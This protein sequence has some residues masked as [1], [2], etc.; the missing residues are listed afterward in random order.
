MEKL[1]KKRW[2]KRIKSNLIEK[3]S[4]GNRTTADHLPI[5][6]PGI[7]AGRSYSGHEEDARL[8]LDIFARTALDTLG[9]NGQ[10]SMPT[11]NAPEIRAFFSAANY[12]ALMEIAQKRTGF[13]IHGETLWEPMN[14]AFSQNITD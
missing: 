3:M 1:N 7:Y 8:G 12:N 5:L 4:S 9:S 14:F 2:G 10:V 6:P 13:P 11:N